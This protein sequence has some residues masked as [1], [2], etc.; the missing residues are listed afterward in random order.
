V[1]F[2]KRVFSADYRRAV[3][4]EAAGDYDEAARAYA[5]AGERAKVAAMHLYRAER[6]P[7]PETHLAELRAAVRWADP[8]EEDG[9]D[10]R[11]RI[12]RAMHGWAKRSGIVSESDRRV[13]REAAAL[14]TEVGDH[15]GAGECHELVGDEAQAAEA[16]Q[17]AGELER[18]ETVLARE[19][20]RRKHAQRVQESFEEYRLHLDGGDRD[21]ALAAI[22]E[23]AEAAADA[24]RAEYRRLAD[25]LTAKLLSDG[26]VVLRTGTHEHTYVGAFP[27]ALGR[28]ATCQVILRDA[29]ISRRHAEIQLA[30]GG[31]ALRDL[32]SKNGTTLGGVPLAA[33]SA[34]P[35]AGSG[36]LGVGEVCRFSF[37]VTPPLLRLSVTG[38]LD[39]G[40]SILASPS[41]LAV[42]EHAELRFLDGKPRLLSRAPLL[43][44]EVV[45]G[46]E[47]QLIRGDRVQI[48]GETIEVVG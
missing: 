39:R 12:A 7:S 34:L 37:A 41:P 35:L 4:A 13:V 29:G 48:G 15:A 26:R 33:G 23:C 21:R 18:L 16:Y 1:T 10:M 38:G 45:T 32:D 25:A 43:L 31:F 40:R 14:F 22:R 36:E 8:D 24:E 6:A 28:E 3:A 17:K 42:G 19:E 27:L 9:R 30:G 46:G 44:N 47:V 11:R 20:T 5:L 2:W